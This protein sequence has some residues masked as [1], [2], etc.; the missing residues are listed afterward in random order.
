MEELWKNYS[1]LQTVYDDYG[2][3]T[4]A[5]LILSMKTMVALQ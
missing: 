2:S 1:E 3:T 4:V 5:L